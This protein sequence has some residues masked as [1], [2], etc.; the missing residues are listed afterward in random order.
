MSRPNAD[1]LHF[2]TSGNTG[3]LGGVG[4]HGVLYTVNINT[5][6][7]SAVLTIKHK[8]TNGATVAVIDASA[9][10]S[11]NYNIKLSNGVFASLAGGNADCT[12]AYG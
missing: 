7:A 10:G 4:S 5:A 6:A 2:T 12:I 11:Y 9:K 3:S 8:D 1:F